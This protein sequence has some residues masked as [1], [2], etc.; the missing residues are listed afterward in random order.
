M[1]TQLI[2]ASTAVRPVSDADLIDILQKARHRNQ[3]HNVTGMLIYRQGVFLQVLEGAFEDVDT[4]W[5]II[6]N[7]TRH[8]NLVV[9]LEQQIKTRAFPDWSMG[10]RN[11]SNLTTNSLPGFSGILDENATPT[12]IA[13]HPGDA[14]ALLR[15]VAFENWQRTASLAGI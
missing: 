1:I 8:E 5:R 2:Y 7:D 6:Q 12:H 4:I 13:A 14:E 15:T 9:V 10:F 11:G 3:E